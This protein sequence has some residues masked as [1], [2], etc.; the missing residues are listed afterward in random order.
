M[1][2]GSTEVVK[3][4]AILGFGVGVVPAAAVERECE[5][6]LLASLGFLP[7]DRL[8]RLGIVHGSVESLSPAARAFVDLAR[9][10]LVPGRRR[11]AL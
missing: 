6:G 5:A 9:E 4:L 1:E 2:L 10:I 7:R 3:Q 11:P 8:R